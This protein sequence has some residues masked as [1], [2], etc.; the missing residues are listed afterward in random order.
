MSQTSRNQGKTLLAQSYLLYRTPFEGK[1]KPSN[2]QPFSR[3][4]KSFMKTNEAYSNT[5]DGLSIVNL[6]NTFDKKNTNKDSQ[7]LKSWN[8]SS[9]VVPSTQLPSLVGYTDSIVKSNETNA[10]GDTMNARTPKVVH[11]LTPINEAYLEFYRKDKNRFHSGRNLNDEFT[12]K[13]QNTDD[14]LLNCDEELEIEQAREE[15]A[16]MESEKAEVNLRNSNNGGLFDYNKIKPRL[17]K[18]NTKYSQQQYYNDLE[19]DLKFEET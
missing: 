10:F 1:F 6:S 3:N 8:K 4:H 11:P 17:M 18:N 2:T 19:N 5:G 16:S 9:V 15:I 7:I 12:C 14:C 13:R